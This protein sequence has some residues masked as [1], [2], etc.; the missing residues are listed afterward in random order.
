LTCRPKCGTS[1]AVP[2]EELVDG[3]RPTCDDWAQFLPVHALG[4][5]CA[6]MADDVW[7]SPWLV[8]KMSAIVI[9]SYQIVT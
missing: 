8:D 4:D 9:A 1:L 7:W 3:A 5:A 6:S 2:I